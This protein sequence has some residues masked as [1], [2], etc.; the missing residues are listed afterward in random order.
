MARGDSI[1]GGLGRQH[2]RRR[3]QVPARPPPAR[4]HGS[5]RHRKEETKKRLPRQMDQPLL[6]GRSS[7]LNRVANPTQPYGLQASGRCLHNTR[8]LI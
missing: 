4:R 2:V 6:L 8:H 1:V 7:L 5:L 3:R